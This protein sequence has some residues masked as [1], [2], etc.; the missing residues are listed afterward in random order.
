MS[1]TNIL[2]VSMITLAVDFTD[3]ESYLALGPSIRMAQELKE[4]LE[5]VPF[6][7]TRRPTQK[8]TSTEHET[9]GE[10]HA[11]VRSNYQEL[12]LRRYFERQGLSYRKIEETDSSAALEGL[13]KAGAAK[14]SIEYAITIFNRF[15]NNSIDLTSKSV[16]RILEELKIAEQPNQDLVLCREKLIERGIFSTPMYVVADQVFMGRQHLPMIRWILTGRLGVPPL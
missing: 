14:K 12:N 6:R 5:V 13:L 11:R 1:P 10:R 15:W 2:E 7:I 9:V 4:Q 8:K 3:P 16:D